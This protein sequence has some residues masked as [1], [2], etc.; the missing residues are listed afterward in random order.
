MDI[1]P[2]PAAPSP[3]SL[4]AHSHLISFS[5]PT[6]P[7][8]MIAMPW[9]PISP[10]KMIASPDRLRAMTSCSI[11]PI[12]VVLIYAVAFAFIHNLRI[13]R[14]DQHAHSAAAW[15]IEVTGDALSDFKPFLQ[16]KPGRQIKG[17]AR[18]RKIIDTP[19]TAS[20]PMSH[21]EKE[22]LN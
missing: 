15:L 4:A 11:T 13:A 2:L 16:N 12:P 6:L 17:L 22:R 18:T 9:R 10:L 8:A 20:L 1:K 3:H 14:D 5:K 7:E 21:R 19:Y